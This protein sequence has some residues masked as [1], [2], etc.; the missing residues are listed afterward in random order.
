MMTIEL[1]PQSVPS[2]ASIKLH[3]Y[4]KTHLL[5]AIADTRRIPTTNWSKCILP[6]PLF[7]VFCNYSIKFIKLQERSFS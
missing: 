4:E 3:Y 7:S 6:T 5:K 2:T 1:L